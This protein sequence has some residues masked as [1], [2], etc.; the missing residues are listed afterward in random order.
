MR[1]ASLSRL[2]YERERDDAAQRLGCRVSVLED[3]DGDGRYESSR[4]FADG[5]VFPAFPYGRASR[6][7]RRNNPEMDTEGLG[8]MAR[9]MGHQCWGIPRLEIR[10]A[11]E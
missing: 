8:I 4:V 5:L 11:R 2:E 10:H 6:Y 3:L 1:L 9:D 7:A